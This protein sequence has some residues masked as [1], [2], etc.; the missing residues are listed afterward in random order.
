VS[1]PILN[2]LTEVLARPKFQSRMRSLNIM[3]EDLIGIVHEL[4]KSCIPDAVDVP[5]LRDPDDAVII[6]TA[7]AAK[8]EVIVS[9]DLDLLVLKEFGNIPILSPTDFL[10]QYLS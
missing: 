2:E 6:G 8:V 4:S 9:G 5:E 3:I 1:D 10:S 7:I